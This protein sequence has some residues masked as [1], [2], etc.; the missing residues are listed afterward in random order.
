MTILTTIFYLLALLILVSTA[1]AITRRNLVH[2]II[3][4][5]LSFFGSAMLFYLFG[6][7][8]LAALEVIIYAG[9]IMIL[10]L[11]IIM[12][13]R[14]DGAADR[15]FP[16]GQ[17]LPAAGL[18][19]AYLAVGVMVVRRPA[20]GGGLLPATAAP[21]D[22][23]RYLFQHH[24]LAIEIVSLLL[25]IALIGALVLGKGLLEERTADSEEDR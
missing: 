11:F 14:M 12:M 7:P 21:R 2:A 15:L 3:Y 18:A 6:A 1:L 8:L 5:I 16:P 13:L 20:P 24:W 10:F 19:L 25:L 17:W 22:F 4:L 23:G 9:A